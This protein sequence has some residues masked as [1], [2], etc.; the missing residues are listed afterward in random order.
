MKRSGWHRA[1]VVCTLGPATDAPGVLTGLVAAGMDVAR[2]NLSHGGTDDH[3]RRID[4][5]RQAARDLEQP[6]A[7]LLDLPGPK[8]RLGRL[9]DSGRVLQEGSI[10]ALGTA[11]ADPGTIPVRDSELLAVLRPGDPVHLADGSV[12]LRVASVSPQR[13]R[14]QVVIGG[15]VRSGSGINV[16]EADFGAI[17]PTEADRRHLEFASSQHVEWVGVSF[18]QGPEDLARVRACL[19]TGD[20]PLL[21]AKI[22]KRRALA[23]LDEIIAAADGVMVA[24]GDLGVETDLAEIPLVQKRIIAAANARARPVVTATQMLESMIEREHPTRAEVTDVA[25]AVLDGTDAV[26]LSGETAVGRHPLAAVRILNRVLTATEAEH[27]DRVAAETIAAATPSRDDAVSFVACQLAARLDAKAIVAAVHDSATAAAIARFRPAAP[28][29]MVTQSERIAR[30]L[31]PIR[32]V[33]AVHGP[34]GGGPAAC[35]DAARRW[36]FARSLAAPG[37]EAVLVFASAAERTSADS[38]RVARL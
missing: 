21:M 28:L 14:C 6:V 20:A 15:T 19:P 17:V 24:R 10:V 4:N 18:V 34:P 22:E 30:A 23:R 1:K 27:A 13:V 2:I 37:D 31:A 35:I 3:A 9:D 32:G 29:V 12:E 7:I 5:V 36:L 16:P 25:N 33:A 11:A 26:M 38:L 8:F